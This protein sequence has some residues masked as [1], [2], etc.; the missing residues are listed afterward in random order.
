M[1]VSGTVDP[2][3][4]KSVAGKLEASLSYES[5]TSATVNAGGTS[6]NVKEPYVMAS[7]ASF[8]A[9]HPKNVKV[10]NN[11]GMDQDGSFVAVGLE[12]PDLTQSPELDNMV[13]P[14]ESVTITADA[15]GFVVPDITTMASNQVLDM[16]GDD[17]VDDLDSNLDGMLSQASSIQEATEQLS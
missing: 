7:F 12:M 15:A 11:K 4:L 14:P 1:T 2:S 16:V 5:N 13:D 9:E 3:A 17:G 8:D 6:R 10:V